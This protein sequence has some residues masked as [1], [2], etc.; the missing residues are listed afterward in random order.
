MIVIVLTGPTSQEISQIVK[1]L[2]NR[3]LNIGKDF[4]F[5]YRT[6]SYDW[7]KNEYIERSTKFTFYNEKEATWFAL[8][9][10]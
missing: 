3:G 4:D 10:T 6:G 8:K 9:W 5:E 1:E 2:K 7:D